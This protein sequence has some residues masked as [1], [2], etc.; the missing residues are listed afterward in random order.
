HDRDDRVV[1]LRPERRHLVEDDLRRI[2]AGGADVEPRLPTGEVEP[3]RVDPGVGVPARNVDRLG[4]ADTDL[5][6]QPDRALGG[7]VERLGVQEYPVAHTANG[8]H[9][10]NSW[11]GTL[12]RMTCRSKRSS[13]LM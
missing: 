3:A 11:Y 2:G 6:R 12:D 7:D 5:P 10:R 8:T 9:Y 4:H 13:R 1:G